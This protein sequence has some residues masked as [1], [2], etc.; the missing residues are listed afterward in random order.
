MRA[1]A[2]ST[3]SARAHELIRVYLRGGVAAVA[4]P[5]RCSLYSRIS[6]AGA[7]RGSATTTAGCTRLSPFRLLVPYAYIYTSHPFPALPRCFLFPPAPSFLGW[8]TD[9]TPLA[10]L[11]CL[12]RSHACRSQPRQHPHTT[13]TGLPFATT[14][15]ISVSLAIGIRSLRARILTLASA[16]DCNRR[17]Y[18]SCRF[19][20]S[21]SAV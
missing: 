19:P 17:I 12:S 3:P 10:T 8:T 13:I 5:R 9:S 21:H 6:E 15:V 11:T 2:V 7:A 20:T 14:S 16:C 18:F 4:I 1:A